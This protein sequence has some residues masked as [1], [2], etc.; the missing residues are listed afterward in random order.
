[1]L[2]NVQGLVGKRF[3][4]LQ[5]PEFQNIFKNND[6]I[7]LTETWTNDLCDIAVNGFHYYVLNRTSKHRNAIRDSGGLII[8]VSDKLAKEDTLLKT[9]DDSIIW[10]KLKGTLAVRNEQIRPLFLSHF[11][12]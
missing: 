6:I 7:L 9:I 3:N 8:Y 5:S 2:F 1:M 12:I 10:L 4:K 11:F